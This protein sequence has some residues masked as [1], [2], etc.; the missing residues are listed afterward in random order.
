MFRWFKQSLIVALSMLALPLA[1]ETLQVGFGPHRPPYVF[2]NQAK[3]LEYELFVA[4]AHSAGFIVQGYFG[5]VARLKVMLEERK[6]D[7]LSSMFFEHEL[8]SHF[9]EPYVTY[10]DMA[11]ALDKRGL[12][13]RSIADLSKYSISTF[14][15]A[16]RIL[17]PEF[18][19]MA[20][21]NK[22][23]R[24]ELRQVNRNKLLYSGRVDVVVAD[25]MI[26]Q[27]FNTEVAHSVDIHQPLRWYDVFKPVHYQGAFAR[28]VQRDRFNIGLAAIRAD[29]T[30][31]RIEAKYRKTL[32]KQHVGR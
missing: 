7:A 24:E 3:G 26:L 32:P 13:I 1:A 14:K 19:A 11:V 18:S 2:E 29:G 8:V 10:R 20:A 6:L 22:A 30:Y 4:A 9:S 28:D 27:F 16:S 25:P 31:A 15:H 21:S 17:G 12:Q 5:P 23:Y